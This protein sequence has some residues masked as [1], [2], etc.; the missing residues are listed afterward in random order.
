MSVNE[1]NTSAPPVLL[2]GVG[3]SVVWP[4]LTTV[5]GTSRC[6][7]APRSMGVARRQSSLV[8]TQ[9]P[10]E[11]AVPPAQARPQAP[12]LAL[13]VCAETSQPSAAAPLQSRKP[14]AQRATRHA[15]PLQAP[16][17]LG[18][19]H[20]RLQPPQWVSEPLVSVSQPLAATPSQSPKPGL[21]AS[22]HTPPPQRGTPFA[23]GH[24]APQ[25]PQWLTSEVTAVS[26]P[27]ET[28]R[29]QSW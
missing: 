10:A 9:S 26:Q 2:H 5:K 16:V 17:A 27:L 8:G 19:R 24:T 15:P 14:L 12:Q 28:T 22:V 21:Q 3:A 29:S 7:A 11:H 18:G 13:S 4:A 25:A 20:A 23:E 1:K 6:V